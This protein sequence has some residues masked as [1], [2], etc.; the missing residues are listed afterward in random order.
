MLIA[1]KSPEHALVSPRTEIIDYLR[2]CE[3]IEEGAAEGREVG[4]D[5][6]KETSSWHDSAYC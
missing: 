4:R 2:L 1:H 3:E 5:L 6:E